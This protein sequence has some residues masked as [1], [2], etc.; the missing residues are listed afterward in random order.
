MKGYHFDLPP[1]NR[2]RYG[3]ACGKFY[4]DEKLVGSMNYKIN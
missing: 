2:G 4:D 3:H 1:L